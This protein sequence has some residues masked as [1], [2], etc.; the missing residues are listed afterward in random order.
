M[1]SYYQGSGDF[2][3]CDNEQG[4]REGHVAMTF[5]RTIPVY[6]RLRFLPF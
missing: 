2:V 3:L 6:P 1:E 5:S 4:I